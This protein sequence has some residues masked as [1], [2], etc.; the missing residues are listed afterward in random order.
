MARDTP[1]FVMNEGAAFPFCVIL[2]SSD[3]LY[4]IAIATPVV[5]Y[6]LVTI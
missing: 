5:S 6:I 2:P 4:V 1:W 3:D